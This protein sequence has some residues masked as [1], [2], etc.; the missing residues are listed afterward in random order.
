[1]LDWSWAE[2]AT[3]MSTVNF[4]SLTVLDTV[5]YHL[6]HNTLEILSTLQILCMSIHLVHSTPLVCL[7]AILRN[8]WEEANMPLCG[9][10]WL[11][12]MDLSPATDGIKCISPYF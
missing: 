6:Q 12:R 10:H 1:M 9:R 8:T 5:H 3:V 7:H 2:F 11:S 4:E